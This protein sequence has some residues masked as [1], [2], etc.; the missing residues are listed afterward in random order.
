MI[1]TNPFNTREDIKRFMEEAKKYHPNEQDII[2]LVSVFKLSTFLNIVII[3]ND[4]LNHK[5]HLEGLIYDT[6]NSIIAIFNLRERYLH[7]NLRSI[8]EHIARIALNKVYQGNEFDGTV[9]RKDFEYLKLE[10][11]SENWKFMHE[12]YIRACHYVHF[13]P[14]AQLNVA[15]KFIDLLSKDHKT[16]PSKQILNLQKVI[17]STIRIFIEYFEP[18]I[19]NAFFRSQGELRYLLGPSLYKAY[20]FKAGRIAV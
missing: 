20:E 7:L 9:R 2:L 4:N 12:T 18:E 10:R 3:R 15:A 13:S 16:K 6:L 5:N 1:S 11:A 17:S 14:E 8:I 19:S